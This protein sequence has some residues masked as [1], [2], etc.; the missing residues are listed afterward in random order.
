M[1]IRL[2]TIPILL[3]LCSASAFPAAAYANH[4]TILQEAVEDGLIVFKLTESDEIVALIGEPDSL[5]TRPDGG[6]TL[7]MWQ[8]PAA[9]LLFGRY[10][11]DGASPFTILRL[12]LEDEVID[13]G[14]NRPLALRNEKDLARI[15]SF[16]GF[17]NVSLARLDLK[18]HREL[19][20]EMT[21]DTLTEWPP[22]NR[23]P[24]GFDPA[25]L[26]EDGRNPGLGLRRLHAESIDGRG[27]GIAIIDQPLLTDHVEYADNLIRY[28]ASGLE[29]FRPQ[30]HASPVA[31]IAVGKGIGVAPG[32]S[33]SFYA[34][35]MWAATNA[36]YIRALNSIMDLNRTL[37]IS[38]RIR[39]VSISDGAFSANPEYDE[40]TELL[41]RAEAEGILVITCAP[42]PLH[43][44][45]LAIKPGG[46]P[47]LPGSYR[48][49]NYASPQ[50]NLRAPTCNRTLASH[51]G[52]DVYTF[53][54]DGGRSWAAPYLAGCAALAWQ[55]NPDLAP[56][57]IR[58]LLIDTATPADAGPV[59]N[60]RELVEAARKQ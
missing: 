7:Q 38:E 29:G 23:L 35:P 37:S 15:D 3:A 31:S 55:V 34:V 17:Q 49:S 41:D 11:R 48:A 22:Q 16:N 27:V 46:N 60:P 42:G 10:T 26:L 59:V 33:L 36:H 57:Q 18:S 20:A 6:M 24:S 54:R 13:I 50:D 40:W 51:R 5:E 8:Y 9:R 12:W 43:I 19:L 32:S 21:F 53:E 39:V 1:N 52:V 58:R 47:D 25:G 28:D 14:Q 4:A 56:G 45:T 30:M 2:M 44:G